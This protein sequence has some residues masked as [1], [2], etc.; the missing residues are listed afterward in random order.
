MVYGHRRSEQDNCRASASSARTGRA[1]PK[2][3]SVVDVLSTEK[4]PVVFT[5]LSV[6]QAE[7]RALVNAEICPPVRSGD[8]DRLR[9]GK[10]VAIIDGVLK[11]EPVL[12]VGEIRRALQRGMKIRG[13]ASLGALRAHQTHRDGMEGSG[14]VYQAYVSGHIEGTDEIKVLYDPFSHR[15]VTVP[16]VNVRFCLLR[17]VRRGTVT[18]CDA[19]KAMSDL[20]RIPPEERS[21]RAVVVELARL[22]GRERLK[23]AFKEPAGMNSNIKRRDALEMLQ[24]I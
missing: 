8:L 7:A 22:L 17:L 19:E 15:P 1:Y 23:A 6:S 10:S 11:P 16:L 2:R 21:R 5:G 12:S 3:E 20:K 24:T 14:W 13:A 4:Q 9:D 18:L